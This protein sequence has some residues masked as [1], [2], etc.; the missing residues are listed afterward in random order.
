GPALP[1][2]PAVPRIGSDNPYGVAV[3]AAPVVVREDDPTQRLAQMKARLEADPRSRYVVRKDGRDHSPFTAVELLQ[4]I[5][6]HIFLLEHVLRDTI[7]ND[8]R[9]INDWNEFR[10][11]AEHAKLNQDIK[12]EKQ[13]FAATVQKEREG[14][15]YKTL[16]G[17][18]ILGVVLA[19]ALG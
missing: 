7:S 1:K 4:Q 19:A 15:Q 2:A 3:V 9:F 5:A 12:I 6:Q 10:P 13:A 17:V 14:A 18:A 11:F 8:E 16:V